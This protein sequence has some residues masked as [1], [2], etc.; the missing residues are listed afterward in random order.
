MPLQAV[1]RPETGMASEWMIFDLGAR[2]TGMPST[3]RFEAQGV[4]ID[5]FTRQVLRRL[6]GFD[7]QLA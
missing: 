5:R 4:C 2:D 7:F 6:L 3:D 1:K